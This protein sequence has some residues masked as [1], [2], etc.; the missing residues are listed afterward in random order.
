[1][2]GQETMGAV[3]IT[4]GD[5]LLLGRTVDTN[6][7]WL[8]RELAQLGIPVL[9]RYTVADDEEEIRSAL[10]ESLGRVRLL[11]LT[12]GLG[13]TPDDLTREV[14]ARHLERPLHRDDEI[15]EDIRR[16]FRERGVEE[17]PEANEKVALVPE[18]A[19]K[20]RNPHGT[21][22]GLV[23][24]S[25]GSLVVLLPGVPREMKG[26]FAGELSELLK[27]RFQGVLAPVYT[28][29]IHTTG[30]PESV[31]AQ[32]VAKRLPEPPEGIGLAFLPDLR[33]VDLRLTAR[34]IDEAEAHALFRQVE[35]VLAP[36]VD[37]W[38]FEAPSGDLAEALLEELRRRG[39]SLAV[40]E[41][42]TGGLVCTRLTNVPGASEVLLGGVVAYANEVKEKE[43]GVDPEVLEANGA[44]SRE[45]AAA[46]ATGV[47]ERLGAHCGIGITGIAGPG[48]GTPERPVG[49]V[50][51]AAAVKGDTVARIER[52]PGDRTSVRERAAQAAMALLLRRCREHTGP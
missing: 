5:E 51:Y 43:L 10:S 41:S 21:A 9:R 48:G 30:I 11:L 27:R 26:I 23:L 7:A 32:E 50:W 31:L 24:E 35:E 47:A 25:D 16:R 52:F 2:A 20:L 3:I 34:G 15:L 38:R 36:V 18:G 42:C 17:L 49:T 28:R 40:A 12:G 44:V 19:R 37:P 45:V 4:V 1:M 14:V 39:W 8:S 29:T 33:G 46:M 22:P 6:A 13:P